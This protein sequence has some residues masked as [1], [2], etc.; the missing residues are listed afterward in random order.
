[1]FFAA[2]PDVLNSQQQ[3]PIDLARQHGYSRIE[4][5]L[6]GRPPR[7]ATMVKADQES[8]QKSDAPPSADQQQPVVVSSKNADKQVVFLWRMIPSFV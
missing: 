1:M 2:F 3:S 8:K 5:V 6:R 7:S 4:D